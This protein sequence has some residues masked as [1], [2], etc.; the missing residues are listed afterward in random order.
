MEINIKPEDI[1]IYVKEAILKSTIG[2]EIKTGIQAAMQE[3]L[4]G[5]RS[6]V[7]EFAIKYLNELVKEYMQRDDI[8]PLIIEAIAKTITPQVIE[9][10]V[11]EGCYQIERRWK[12]R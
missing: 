9:T 7:K 10:I 8:K 2:T 12:D 6:P 1:D 4:S 11:K 3:I 5:Y